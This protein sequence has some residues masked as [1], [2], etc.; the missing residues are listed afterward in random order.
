M[1]PAPNGDG[2]LDCFQTD[3]C[4]DDPLKL[5]PGACGCGVPDDDRDGDGIYDCND[6][7]PDDHDKAVPGSCGCGVPD[8]DLDADG[9][10][11]CHDNCPETKNADQAECDGNGVGAACDVDPAECCGDGVKDVHETDVD[12]GGGACAA[13]VYGEGCAVAGDCASGVCLDQGDADTCGCAGPGTCPDG[14]CD[15]AT[16]LCV[17]CLVNGDCAGATDQCQPET[18]DAGAS[19]CVA[20]PLDCGERVF[21]GVVEGPGGELASIRCTVDG[22]GVPD[23]DMESGALKLYPPLCGG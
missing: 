19:Q 6:L 20:S 2:E 9:V 11:D 21:Y 1:N 7:C 10:L 18:C 5:N 3:S 8:G 16:S 4:L 13:C 23:C 12:C 15:A 17:E 14:V 22:G